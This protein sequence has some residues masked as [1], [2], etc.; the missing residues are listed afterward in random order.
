MTFKIQE[1]CTSMSLQK[2]ALPSMLPAV[3]LS[4]REGFWE[5]P[6]IFPQKQNERPVWCPGP[7]VF[8]FY[9]GFISKSYNKLEENTNSLGHPS[10]CC[11]SDRNEQWKINRRPLWPQRP[12]WLVFS[13]DW[14]NPGGNNIHNISHQSE[15]QKQLGSNYWQHEGHQ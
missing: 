15:W 4:G 3:Q 10:P 2:V 13:Y 8:F 14:W 5:E 11:A 6:G 7:P 1:Y 12:S 9:C